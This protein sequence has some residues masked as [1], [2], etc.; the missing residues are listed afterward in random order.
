MNFKEPGEVLGVVNLK[1]IET[2]N[3]SL[4]VGTGYRNTVQ[5][6]HP[7]SFPFDYTLYVIKT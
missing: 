1:K 2:Y 7:V 4:S 3:L 6:A 5:K